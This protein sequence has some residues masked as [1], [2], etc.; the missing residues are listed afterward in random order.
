MTNGQ[1]R[2]NMKG[3]QL[4]FAGAM[5]FTLVGLVHTGPAVPSG[6][7]N[8]AVREVAEQFYLALNVMFTG[9]LEP[10]KKV[11][12]HAEDVTYM[13]P[14]GGFRVGWSQVLADWE[15]QAAMKLGGEVKPV[16][17]RVTVGRDLAVAS[18][19]EIGENAGPEAK[20]RTVEIRAT[21]L[22]RKEGGEW[23]VIGHHT[24]ILPFLQE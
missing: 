15:A 9:D 12:S 10:M 1:G 4:A 21:N 24:D 2:L 16:D 14:G 5:L 11:W 17:M 3:K 19:Y 13:G 7:D 8:K 22:F 6:D 23:K 18:N 20:P